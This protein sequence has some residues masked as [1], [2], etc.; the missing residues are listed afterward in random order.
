M[1][2]I[3]GLHGQVKALLCCSLASVPSLAYSMLYS[4]IHSALAFCL[5]VALCPTA[6]P[7]N[8][9]PRLAPPSSCLVS[10][11]CLLARTRSRSLP[12]SR[13]IMPWTISTCTWPLRR[14]RQQPCSSGCF[15][16]PARRSKYQGLGLQTGV[17]VR[18]LRSLA[19]SCSAQCLVTMTS[20]AFGLLAYMSKVDD[21]CDA[22]QMVTHD[23][24]TVVGACSNC[25]P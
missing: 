18:G 5:R 8:P 19:S 12:P 22:P 25:M 23:T 24:C 13:R 10:K 15:E 7:P 11:L 2:C 9:S 6:F 14:G 21:I 4:P 1:G 20:S 17:S 3:Y 16:L